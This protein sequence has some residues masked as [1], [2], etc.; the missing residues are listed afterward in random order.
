MPDQ[1]ADP[2]HSGHRGAV[3]QGRVNVFP[4]FL[5]R[6]SLSVCLAAKDFPKHFPC[7]L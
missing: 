2:K 1:A 3:A 5:E 7:A 6:F 4:R